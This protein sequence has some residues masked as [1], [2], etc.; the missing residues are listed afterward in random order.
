MIPVSRPD[1]TPEDVA[2]IKECA[3]SGWVSGVSPY[4]EQ[5]EQAFAEYIDVK[6]AVAVNSGSTALDLALASLGIGRGDEVIVPAFTM[7]ASANAVRHVGAKPV[8]VDCERDTWNIDYTKL[9]QAVTKR[10][11]AVMPVHI[12]GHPCQQDAVVRISEIYGLKVIEDAAEALGAEFLGYK[13]GKISDLGC[14]SLYA[15]KICTTGEGGVITTTSRE[16]AERLRWMRSNCFGK[17]G[18]HFYHEAAGYGFR[19]GGLQAALGLGQIRRADKYVS[20]H[21]AHA[22]AY[23]DLLEPL[24]WFV[25]GCHCIFNFHQRGETTCACTIGLP[26]ARPSWS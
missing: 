26:S 2:L 8:F 3:E 7:V 20:A 11:K 4:V 25:V 6:Y 10:T 17:G 1:V 16:R 12:Y 19:M 15:N 13:V 23:M 22:R 24:A 5:F 21:R 18:K 14:F 9:D